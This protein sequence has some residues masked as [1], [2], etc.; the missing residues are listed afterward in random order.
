[1]AEAVFFT[2]PR[3]FRDIRTLSYRYSSTRA[4]MLAGA[5]SGTAAIRRAPVRHKSDSLFSI[6]A[7]AVHSVS[8]CKGLI[9]LLI[10]SRSHALERRTCRARIAEDPA[11]R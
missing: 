7:A 2:Q 9:G 1:M 10:T 5:K 8:A 6:S 11:V 3:P 4:E